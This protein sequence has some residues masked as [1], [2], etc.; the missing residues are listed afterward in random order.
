MR[1]VFIILL[2]SLGYGVASAQLTTSRFDRWDKNKDGKLI[3]LELPEAFRKNFDKVDADGDGFISR[4]EDAVFIQKKPQQKLVPLVRFQEKR[5]TGL[6][7]A[8]TENPRQTLDLYLPSE[9]SESP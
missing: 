5:L 2:I 6:A 7:Y 3:R 9:K 8:G 1:S 4:E